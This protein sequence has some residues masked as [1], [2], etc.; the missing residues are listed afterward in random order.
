MSATAKTVRT[1]RKR[2]RSA[3]R[4]ADAQVGSFFQD[5]DELVKRVAHMPD[6]HVSEISSRVGSAI[7]GVRRAFEDGAEIAGKR[8]RRVVTAADDFVHVSP[9]TAIGIALGVGALS[10]WFGISR[11]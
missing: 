4:K 7:V 1:T 6:I 8:S 11:R 5:V 3:N 2:A 10:A 9:W